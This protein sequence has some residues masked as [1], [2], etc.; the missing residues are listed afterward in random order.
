MNKKIVI[1]IILVI[2]IVA[3]A[4]FVASKIKESKVNYDITEVTSYNYFK[5]EKDGRFG[6]IDK[7]GNTIIE[8]K[9]DNIVIPNLEKDLFICYEQNN[10]FVFNSSNNRILEQY[11][12]IQQI[13]L[14]NIV[15]VF[16]YEKSVLKYKKD[17]KYGL[18]DFEGK[19]ITKNL[20]DTIENLQGTE[21]K[22]LVSKDGKY[23]V[24]N[25]NG[26]EIVST[27]YNNITTDG[28]YSQENKYLKSG[29]V[30]GK[31]TSEGYRYGYICYDGRKILNEEYNSIERIPD[32]ENVYLIVAKDGRF[33]LYENSNKII[34]TEYQFITYTDNG[35]LLIQK[36]KNYGI[37]NLDGKIVVNTK[38]ANIQAKGIYMYAENSDESVVYDI[39]G[40][41]KDINFNKV[42]YETENKEYRVFTLLNNEI[43]YYGIE[44][45]L[46][47]TLVQPSYSYIEYAFRDYFIAKNQYGNLGVINANGKVLIEPK[48]DTLQKI[49]GKNILQAISPSSNF[50]EFYSD[51]LERICT[52][53]NCKIENQN[54]YITIYNN[55][56]K[57]YFDEYGNKLEEDSEKLR[58]ILSKN[59]PETIGN[60]KKVQASLDNIYYE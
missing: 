36:N 6:I 4:I 23:G 38:Y 51:K 37:A 27:E 7:E 10:S 13:E 59:F 50:T 44:N 33:G 22:F 15:S 39:N 54:G 30:T 46:E 35:A 55:K 25:A 60:Y 3:L 2:L 14:K 57:Y 49:K 45:K 8:A 12:E 11:D 26:Y 17:G 42:V 43:V 41:K 24:I 9:Y 56:E 29:F 21:G 58:N 53:E 32:K 47:T 19:E 31:R 52:I 48:Y 20:Y 40:S 5:Y 1:T 28:Y 34:N 16:R 18:C